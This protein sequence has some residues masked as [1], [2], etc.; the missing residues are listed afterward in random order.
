M[1]LT[2]GKVFSLRIWHKISEK[3]KKIIAEKIGA[4]MDSAR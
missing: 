2:P 1:S 3:E 4:A